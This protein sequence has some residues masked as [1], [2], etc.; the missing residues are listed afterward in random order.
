METKKISVILAAAALGAAAALTLAGCT[1]GGAGSTGAYGAGSGAA[2]PGGGASAS[3]SATGGNAD[4]DRLSTGSTSLGTVVVDGQGMT[5]Y[6]Y[7]QDT[8]GETASTCTGAC[9]AQWPPV[10]SSG[11]PKVTGVTGTVSTIAWPNG[12]R[13]V[14][15]DGLPIYTFAG[16]SAKGDV[17]GQ[18]VA[19]TWWAVSPAGAKIT[20]PAPS[21]GASGY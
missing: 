3:S 11:T 18:L 12:A 16:D 21:S 9:A 5:V 17:N 19:N 7:G 15:L 14:T 6:F 13:Q 4:G 2:S 10:T 20:A 8:K 1:G